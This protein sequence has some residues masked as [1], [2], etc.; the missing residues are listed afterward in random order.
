MELMIKIHL[1]VSIIKNSW[2]E[3]RQETIFNHKVRLKMLISK[4]EFSKEQKLIHSTNTQITAEYLLEVTKFKMNKIHKASNYFRANRLL[5]TL[6]LLFIIHKT[7]R[8]LFQ[9]L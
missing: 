4:Q 9:E 1:A 2:K 5:F 6:R 7:G 3:E 8:N